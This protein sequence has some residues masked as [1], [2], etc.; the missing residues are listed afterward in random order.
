MLSI[1]TD[2][3]LPKDVD[4]I[5]IEISS[6]GSSIFNNTYTPLGAGG[7][8]VPATLGILPGSNAGE[9]VDIRVIGL[10][11]HTPVVLREAV[12]T[13]PA[14]RMA[15]L[16]MPMQWLCVGEVAST[17]PGAEPASSCPA[18]Q[19]CIAGTCV[20]DSVDSSSLPSYDPT[21]VFGGASG[22][23][24][25]GGTCLDTVACFADG[26]AAAVDAQCTIAAPSG[27]KGTNVAL[28]A[29]PTGA[30]ICGPQACLL[31]LDANTTDGTGW[32]TNAQGR[33]ALPPAVCAKL[34]SKAIESV[35]VTTACKTKDESIPTCGPWNSVSNQPATVDAGAP[36]G[37][38]PPPGSGKVN[39]TVAGLG[40]TV[41]DAIGDLG[42]DDLPYLS[43]GTAIGTRQILFAALSDHAGL[44]P[45]FESSPVSGSQPA[46]TSF[47]T[48]IVVGADATTPVGPGTYDFVDVAAAGDA[49]AVP[50]GAFAIA[51]FSNMNAT[52][53]ETPSNNAG[54]ATSGNVQITGVSLAGI[55][56]TFTANF[57][58]SDSFT[59]QF[60]APICDLGQ[61]AGAGED[62][63]TI[64]PPGGNGEGGAP[65][66]DGGGF[67]CA[68]LS[69]IDLTVCN[70]LLQTGC[71]ANQACIINANAQAT[72][73]TVSGS[74]TG[75]GTSCTAPSACAAGTECANPPD[76]GVGP[77]DGGVGV[78]QNFC[79]TSADCSFQNGLTCKQVTTGT[80]G[81][82]GVCSN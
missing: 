21:Q 2:M 29:G 67:S 33:I 30:G 25:S 16:R 56:G 60:T 81:A 70:P 3:N 79:C 26:F 63:G 55:T 27:G 64:C 8:K 15:L 82:Y 36:T 47:M 13:V 54:F 32:T 24:G 37:V 11:A 20:D 72:C 9:Q 17:G 62:A 45:F 4:E 68:S 10:L 6:N 61:D 48:V 31:P 35:A 5:Q 22:P 7:T 49:G 42:V 59:G 19:T 66:A 78:C 76:G 43:G 28:V 23:G 51:S 41:A 1:Q 38:A 80:N 53:G 71:S 50:N 12:T 18:N 39:G 65:P 75:Q 77:A 44:C 69:N 74:A 14:D 46:G 57:T 58:G 73:V 34:K 52:C 40:M